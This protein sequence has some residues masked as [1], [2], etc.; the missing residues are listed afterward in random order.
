MSMYR[1]HGP[2][3]QRKGDWIVLLGHVLIPTCLLF[4][5]IAVCALN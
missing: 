4:A 2:Y 3:R 5:A 1:P